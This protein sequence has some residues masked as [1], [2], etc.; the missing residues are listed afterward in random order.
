[1]DAHWWS[2]DRPDE[3][4]VDGGRLA[5]FVSSPQGHPRC[6]P[7][8]RELVTCR[9]GR[10]HVYI[11]VSSE[12]SLPLLG[13]LE[14]GGWEMHWL[15]LV[16]R[17]L[18]AETCVNRMPLHLHGVQCK[19]SAQH[20]QNHTELLFVDT[21]SPPYLPIF[22]QG[23]LPL[24]LLFVLGPLPICPFRAFV[25]LHVV[26]FF[27]LFALLSVFVFLYLT[28]P[29]L[30]TRTTQAHT[31]THNYAHVIDVIHVIHT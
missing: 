7:A 19:S 14:P 20:T 16:R 8:T 23:I 6:S 12:Q 17:T 18:A 25:F 24:P 4:G 13:S 29:P 3:I 2:D 31:K 22:T 1:M 10:Q 15:A 5:R 26:L 30:P 27:V 9:A 21:T 28:S 11:E